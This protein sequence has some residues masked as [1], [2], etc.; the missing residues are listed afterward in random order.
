[1]TAAR[2]DRSRLARKRAVS[3]RTARVW[4]EDG[5]VV[6]VES[7]P[8]AR[9]TGEDAEAVVA[10]VLRQVDAPYALVVD[11]RGA[12]SVDRDA[13]RVYGSPAAGKRLVALAFVADTPLSRVLAASFLGLER[14]PFPAR[15]FDREEDAVAWARVELAAAGE[16]RP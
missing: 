2:R 5:C 6:H 15:V 14:P 8:G 13:R 16:A 4:S 11:L 12:L 7:V 9:E 3:T 1:M 10:A